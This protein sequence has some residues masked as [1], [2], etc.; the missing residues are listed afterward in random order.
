MNAWDNDTG[1]DPLPDGTFLLTPSRSVVNREQ[2]HAWR[3]ARQAKRSSP[4]NDCVGLSWEEIERRQG[5][6]LTR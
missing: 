1:S 2:F 4:R 3:L 5:G 6:K